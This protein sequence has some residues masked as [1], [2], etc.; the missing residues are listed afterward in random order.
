[1]SFIDK[2]A[3]IDAVHNA[4]S[5]AY[6]NNCENDLED[7]LCDGCHRKYINWA[8]SK[9]VIERIFDAMPSVESR[10]TGEW[11]VVENEPF[12]PTFKCSVCGGQPAIDDFDWFLSDYCPHCGAEM[13]RGKDG[14]T[15]IED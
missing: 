2:E 8:A 9:K 15:D 5:Y 10:K 12:A 14:R 1:M 6:C 3:A 11:L 4:F 13:I 7:E